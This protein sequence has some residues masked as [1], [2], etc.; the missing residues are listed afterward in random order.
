MGEGKAA[1][2]AAKEKEKEQKANARK[3]LRE[4]AAKGLLG[5]GAI[6]GFLEMLE[7]LSI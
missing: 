4:G 7:G 1:R 5:A 3:N 6:G 2:D